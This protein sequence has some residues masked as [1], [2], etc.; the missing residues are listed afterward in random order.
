MGLYAQDT[1]SIYFDLNSAKLRESEFEKLNSIPSRFDL[2]STD[3]V[4][5]IGM[6]DSLGDFDANILLSEKRAKETYQYCKRLLPKDLPFRALALG[7][8]TSK[9]G[10]KN[11]RVD[12]V[13]YRPKTLTDSFIRPD[14]N[15]KTTLCYYVNYGLLHRAHIRP[16]T[17]RGKKYVLIELEEDPPKILVYQGTVDKNGVFKARK[18]KW[19]LT[20]TGKAWWA[21]TRYTATIPKADYDRFRIFEIKPGP[22]TDCDEAF[23]E[24][25]RITVQDKCEDVDYFLM[26]NLQVSPIFLNFREVAI[27]VPREY[28]LEDATYH[29]GCNKSRVLEWETKNFGKKKRYY[30]SR[31]PISMAGWLA[32]ISREME[33]CEARHEPSMCEKALV[34]HGMGGCGTH[35]AFGINFLAEAGIQYQ[36]RQLNPYL[37]LGTSLSTEFGLAYATIATDR[38]LDIFGSFRYNFFFY[39]FPLNSLSPVKIWTKPNGGVVDRFMVPYIGTE[40]RLYGKDAWNES[41]QNIHIGLARF[42]D[43]GLGFLTIFLHGGITVD[44]NNITRIRPFAQA[45]INVNLSGNRS[46]ILP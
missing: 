20:K 11:R 38:H 4:Q 39:D 22:C 13:F 33:C 41:Q 32:N 19:K 10:E 27:R 7:E 37:A 5:F 46:E 2:S 6:A 31:L 23:D 28:V 3:S 14:T 40:G 16:I 17:V 1:L 45:G 44:Y 34:C 43:S 18:I 12:I 21:K 15:A 26:Y 42:N 9:L 25:P 29:I 36:Q 30:Y 35:P 8:S 24:E